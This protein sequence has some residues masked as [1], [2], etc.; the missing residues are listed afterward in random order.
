MSEFLTHMK[1]NI[2]MFFFIILS[3]VFLPTIF[4]LYG[5]FGHHSRQ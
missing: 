3:T 5:Q 4:N 2:M 1:D